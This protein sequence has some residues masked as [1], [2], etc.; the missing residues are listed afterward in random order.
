MLRSILHF[1]CGFLPGRIIHVDGEPLFERYFLFCIPGHVYAYLHHYLRC[2]PDRGHHDH[3]WRWALAMPLCGGYVESRLD[4]WPFRDED[5]T[6]LYWPF[7]KK[8][9]PFRPYTLTYRDFH[10][11]HIGKN[12]TNWSFF[13]HSPWCKPWGFMA[14][15]GKYTIFDDKIVSRGWW[16]NAPRGRELE[17][18][19]A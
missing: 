13:I 1:V 15:D 3:P 11:V 18:A 10:R 4:W 8:R 14:Y 6:I 12:K 17:R 7:F 5:E 16:H 19:R 2:D 9:R